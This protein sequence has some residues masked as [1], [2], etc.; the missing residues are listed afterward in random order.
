MKGRKAAVGFIF[1]TVLID[2]MGFGII[3]PIVP[4]LIKEL[5]DMSTSEAAFYGGLLTTTYALMQLIFAPVLGGL[6]DK[7]GRRPLLLISLL[8][9]GLDYIVIIFAPNL[10][11][12]FLARI[13][14]GIC[15][16][17]FTV[18]NAYIA[19]ISTSDQRAKNF[20]LIG[21]AFGLGFILG[22]ILGGYLGEIGIRVPFI[23]TAAMTLL[24]WLYGY[25]VVPESLAQE[26]RREFNWKRANPIGTLRSIASHKVI[27]PLLISF[28]IVYVA[29]HATQS[30]WSFFGQEKFGWTPSQI[31]L[32]LSFVGIMVA[33]VQGFVV[34]RVVAKWG[35][36]A[37]V[38]IGFTF[39]TVGSLLFGILTE[40]WM[41]YLVIIPFA[42]SGL[43]GPALQSI[44][45]GQ[46]TKDA[47]GELQGGL[48]QVI[49][50]T[51]IVGPLLMTGI[52]RYFTNP[53][54]DIYFPGAPFILASGLVLIS[55]AVAH[56]SLSR[57]SGEFNP[58]KKE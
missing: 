30:N 20:G 50:L 51:N 55:I 8:G 43:A 28:F 14:S 24:N 34:P 48:T 32:S 33:F 10:A 41:V 42:F 31:G 49:T 9:L 36:V 13:I 6:S 18:A 2:V 37:A 26:N 3:I 52:F 54:N 15:G 4:D 17:S 5:A 27:V 29:G 16:S 19:D 44:M 23:A 38:Y 22:P 12:F 40:G 57:L 39:N 56:S 7:F 58:A 21:A 35:E 53:E 45:A 46:T 25:F 47:Q 11:W 1:V